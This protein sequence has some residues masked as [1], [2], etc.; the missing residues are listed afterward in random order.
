MKKDFINKTKEKLKKEK[1]RIEKELSL[2]AQKNRE[3]ENSWTTK[4]PL[5]DES[6]T[7]GQAIEDAI[8]EVE[9]YVSK[10]PVEHALELRLKEIDIALNKIKKGSYGICEKCKKNIP[11]QRLK[12]KPESLLCVDCQK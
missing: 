6:S 8:G 12:V 10:L 9:D 4:F 2:F 3:E 7:G 1:T 11:L 5:F